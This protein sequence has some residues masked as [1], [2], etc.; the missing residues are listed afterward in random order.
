MMAQAPS[1]VR[2]S[3]WSAVSTPAV[4]SAASASK[5]AVP[6]MMHVC[7]SITVGWIVT[8][9]LL[10]G[11]TATVNLRDGASGAGTILWS[12]PLGIGLLP[13]GSSV[14]LVITGL[15]IQ[16]SVNTAMTLEF[17]AGVASTQMSVTLAGYDLP[18]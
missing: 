8:A 11:V 5:A 17:V 6:G 3:D 18:Q 15:T 13:V 16:G 1:P 2:L 12:L 7:T 14:P 10:A 9:L 4:G